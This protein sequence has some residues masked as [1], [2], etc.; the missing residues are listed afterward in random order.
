M[1]PAI[2]WLLSFCCVALLYY[3]NF[4][5]PVSRKDAKEQGNKGNCNLCI[6]FALRLC[7]KLG[8]A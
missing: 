8:V 5:Q 6:S 7:V 4:A 2:E 1:Q 3:S